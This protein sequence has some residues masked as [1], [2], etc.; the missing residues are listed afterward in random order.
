VTTQLQ[1]IIIIIII[2][3]TALYYDTGMYT[4]SHKEGFILL[5]TVAEYCYIIFITKRSWCPKLTD[6][7]RLSWQRSGTINSVEGTVSIDTLMR[8]ETEIRVH[9]HSTD[10]FQCVHECTAC[11]SMNIMQ[12]NTTP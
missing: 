5:Q 11:H 2:I 9:L 10:T 4:A 8:S 7:F 12:Y 6:S 3:I 1:F